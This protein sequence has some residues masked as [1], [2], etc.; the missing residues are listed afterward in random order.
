MKVL[1]EKVEK[2]LEGSQC[3]G[4]QL[5]REVEKVRLR[6]AGFP[7]LKGMKSNAKACA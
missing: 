7:T 3:E 2:W 5:S 1:W 4:G 6:A